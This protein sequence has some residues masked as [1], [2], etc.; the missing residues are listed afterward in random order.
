MLD[1][2]RGQCRLI[3]RP[4]VSLPRFV[5]RLTAHKK[6]T[7]LAK[8]CKR[9]V[10]NRWTSNRSRLPCCRRPM[11]VSARKPKPSL[12][13]G[14]SPMVCLFLISKPVKISASER[15]RVVWL[16]DPIP[17]PGTQRPIVVECQRE[18]KEN[19]Q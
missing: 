12:T 13:K 15:R 19:N 18:H 5:T 2:G 9:R 16:E 4:L 7:L 6:R 10:A 3:L 1:F 14:N 8:P 17:F 11:Q